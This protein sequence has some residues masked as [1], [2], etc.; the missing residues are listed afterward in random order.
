MWQTRGSVGIRGTPVAERHAG[1]MADEL[2]CPKGHE[3]HWVVGETMSYWRSVESA[4]SEEVRVTVDDLDPQ[5]ELEHDEHLPRKLICTAIVDDDI[6][7]EEM[8][9]PES[10]RVEYT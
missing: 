6:C 10:T 1:T 4:T 5:F 8:P 3:G 2:T 9:V 7:G